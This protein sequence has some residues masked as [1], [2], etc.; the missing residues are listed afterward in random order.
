MQEVPMKLEEQRCTSTIGATPLSGRQVDG[1]LPQVPGWTLSGRELR[2]EF[3]LKD[4]RHALELVDAVAAIAD[5]QD[6]HPDIHISYNRVALVLTTHKI[7]GLSM[8]DFI[9]AAR[10]NLL[11]GLE[12]AG[13][14]A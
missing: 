5:E 1:L 11:P 10:I 6:H 9:L 13:K 4:F 8:N 14:A 7:G 12:S 2:R 3:K